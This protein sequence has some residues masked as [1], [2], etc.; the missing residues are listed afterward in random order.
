MENNFKVK[1]ESIEDPETQPHCMRKILVLDFEEFKNNVL[2]Q[3]EEF[4]NNLV[5]SLYAGDAYIL[6]GAFS[7]EYFKNLI[8]KTHAHGK[9]SESSYFPMIE[10]CPDFHRI[11]DEEITKNY[12]ISTVRHSHY[13]FPWNKD[14]LNLFESINKRWRV[15]KFLGGFRL[16]EYENNTPLDGVV[17]RIQ[18]ARYPSGG[19]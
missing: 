16:D 11:V 8:I 4:V 7:K 13:F 5:E 17:D 1:W 15:F 3:D 12:S 9:K 14:P 6:K 19:G 10:G 2:N 18:I